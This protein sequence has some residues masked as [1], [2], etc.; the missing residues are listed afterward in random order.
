MTYQGKCF[1]KHITSVFRSFSFLQFVS[2]ISFHL[3]ALFQQLSYNKGLKYVTFLYY[4]SLW[5]IGENEEKCT[6]QAVPWLALPER[7]SP[8]S[9]Q[10]EKHTRIPSDVNQSRH[11]NGCFHFLLGSFMFVNILQGASRRRVEN[12]GKYVSAVA[13]WHR[14]TGQTRLCIKIDVDGPHFI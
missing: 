2:H 14:E 3:H 13:G 7:M 9:S 5:L 11:S 4:K 1:I 10:A 6:V 12:D 8:T